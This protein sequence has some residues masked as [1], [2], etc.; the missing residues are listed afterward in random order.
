MAWFHL[1]LYSIFQD[2]SRAQLKPV[3][4]VLRIVLNLLKSDIGLLNV[5]N[6]L[7]LWFYLTNCYLLL[8]SPKYVHF[9]IS[10]HLL[11]ALVLLIS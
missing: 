1:K 7:P 9:R 4:A 8:Y 5:L 10:N 11:F 3:F 6:A 2:L